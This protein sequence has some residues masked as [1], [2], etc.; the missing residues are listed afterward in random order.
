MGH[1]WRALPVRLTTREQATLIRMIRW[2][3]TTQPDKK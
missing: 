2:F 3:E 1:Q